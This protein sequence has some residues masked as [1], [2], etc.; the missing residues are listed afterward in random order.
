M[1]YLLNV[2]IA[3]DQLANAMLA[4]HADESLSSRAHRAYAQGKPW[5]FLRSVINAIF[6]WQADHC[7]DAHR[8]ELERRQLPPSLRG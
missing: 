8:A 4:G 7:A 1:A 5:G 2:L 3:V 6:F